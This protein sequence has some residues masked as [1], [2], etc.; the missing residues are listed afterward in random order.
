MNESGTIERLTRL[1]ERQKVA[2][3]RQ[4]TAD[5]RAERIEAAVDELVNRSRNRDGQLAKVNDAIA[6]MLP[7][8]KAVDDY[9]V[10]GRVVRRVG[11]W[12]SA[13]GVLLTASWAWL[14]DHLPALAKIFNR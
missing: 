2:D 5:E 4:R 8:V 10:A 14:G 1:E 7:I 11:T 9:M 13:G 12:A 6:S 3:D